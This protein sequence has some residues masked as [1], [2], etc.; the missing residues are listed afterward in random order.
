VSKTG[1]T[2]IDIDLPS[3]TNYLL[4]TIYTYKLQFLY[5]FCRS[6]KQKWLSMNL[7]AFVQRAT[8]TAT[9]TET[10]PMTFVPIATSVSPTG[11][12]N[13]LDELGSS[14]ESH[15]SYSSSS[16]APSSPKSSTYHHSE[17]SLRHPRKR[18]SAWEIERHFPCEESSKCSK[19][20]KKKTIRPHLYIFPLVSTTSN[21]SYL[22]SLFFLSVFSI[23]YSL[24]KPPEIRF[25]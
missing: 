10:T 3:S 7:S 25:R 8:I 22:F 18:R 5:E 23:P 9:T 6:V 1:K 12:S 21:E 13:E 16:S 24:L 15:S 14:S 20:R 4:S 17:A 2:S 11:S 19:V